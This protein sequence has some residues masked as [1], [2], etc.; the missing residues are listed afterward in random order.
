MY[1]LFYTFKVILTLFLNSKYKGSFLIKYV[2]CHIQI[3]KSEVS[4]QQTC[5]GF[6][7]VVLSPWPSRPYSP[8]PQVY[9]SPL[10]VMAALWELPHAMSL[11]RL[12][13]RASIRRGLS[14][15]QRLKCP[16]FPS[17]PSPQEKT[18]PS[19]VRA[20]ECLPPV[21]MTLYREQCLK[22]TVFNGLQV[23]VIGN[24]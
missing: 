15:F 10:E 21:Y 12:D 9:R 2:F 19:V 20:S 16:S 17:S 7:W 18:F 1:Q 8:S 13:F 3:P 24:S 5:L 6:S 11:T 14:Q 23:P 22:L 4:Q